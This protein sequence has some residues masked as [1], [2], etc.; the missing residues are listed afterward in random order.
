MINPKKIVASVLLLLFSSQICLPSL[1]ADTAGTKMSETLKGSEG[2]VS[3]TEAK[4][5]NAEGEVDHQQVLADAAEQIN[6]EAPVTAATPEAVIPTA[7]P[8]TTL[9]TGRHPSDAELVDSDE[10]NVDEDSADAEFVDGD[11]SD[12]IVV[13]EGDPLNDEVLQPNVNEAL[14]EDDTTNISPMI[15]TNDESSETDQMAAAAKK[16]EPI[17]P[18]SPPTQVE[19]DENLAKAIEKEISDLNDKL[20]LV[21]AEAEKQS[22]IIH[23]IL[24]DAEAKWLAAIH[25]KKWEIAL[26]GTYPLVQTDPNVQLATEQLMHRRKL[27][28]LNRQ[29]D[30]L[31]SNGFNKYRSVARATPEYK[32]AVLRYS[33]ALKLEDTIQKQIN[34]KL[35]DWVVK[36]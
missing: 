33:N 5:S 3:Q 27:A 32:K 36:T 28:N 21:Q 15:S 9:P 35:G 24:S 6:A 2:S 29:L 4:F 7:V 23:T 26:L 11:P 25:L 8:P 30:N 13:D 12:E 18:A 17:P 31:N 10:V 14:T 16:P 20:V 19:I 1:F 34:A 22:A